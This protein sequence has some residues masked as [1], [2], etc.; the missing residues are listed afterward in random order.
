MDE[1]RHSGLSIYDKDPLIRYLHKIIRIGVKALAVLMTVIILWG[2]VDVMWVFIR[3]LGQ[4][5]YFLLKV[6]DILFLFGSILVV[7]IAIEIFLNITL[8]LRDDI[9]H[10][11]LVV[12]TAL[13]AIARKVIV[14]DFKEISPQYVFATAAVVLALGITYWIVTKKIE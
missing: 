5:P 13:M 11:K 6:N 12:A 7:L 10:V 8:Y 4:P 1:E 3:R 14:F 2:V 9:I